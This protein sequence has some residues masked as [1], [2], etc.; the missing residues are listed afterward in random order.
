MTRDGDGEADESGPERVRVVESGAVGDSVHLEGTYV[1]GRDVHVHLE[2]DPERA[3]LYMYQL[4]PD[5]GVREPRRPRPSS[6]SS[7]AVLD[8]PTDLG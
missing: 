4:P 5:I 6:G 7:A 8:P 3:D 1:G 2:S